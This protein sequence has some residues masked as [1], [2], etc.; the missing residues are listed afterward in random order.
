[1]KNSYL[2]GLWP[3]A[4]SVEIVDLR[5]LITDLEESN[6]KIKESLEHG[7]TNKENNIEC[8]C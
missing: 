5:Q 7:L 8:G 6:D 3:D 4:P 1:M 2:C